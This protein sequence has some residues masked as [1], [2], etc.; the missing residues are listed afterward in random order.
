MYYADYFINGGFKSVEDGRMHLSG[1]S[2]EWQCC[3]GTF[4]EDVAEYANLLYYQDEEGLY[5]S[6]Y[7]PSKVSFTVNNTVLTLENTSL[8]P[9][10]KT[11]RFVLH[12]A[13]EESFAL[14]FRVPSWA[15]EKNEMRVNGEVV[16]IPMIPNT[17]AVLERNWKDQDVI[18]IDFGFVLRFEAVDSYAPEVAALCFGPLVLVCNKMTLFAGDMKNPQEWIEPIWKEGYS[19]AF[20]TKPGHVKPFGHLTRDFYPYY[21]VPAMEWYYM[22]NKIEKD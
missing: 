8:Y 5:I 20:R 9:K 12:D 10:E 16:D 2:F 17:W 19:F 14:R 7:L 11:L 18:E 22:Y 3:T 13:G 4:P 1:A 6:Q 15:T 21:E